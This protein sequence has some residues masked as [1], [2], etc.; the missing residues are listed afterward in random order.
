[1][2]KTYLDRRTA[3]ATSLREEQT[4]LVERYG[5]KVGVVGALARRQLVK[6]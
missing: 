6:D 1:M 5:E 2:V 4:E 3:G